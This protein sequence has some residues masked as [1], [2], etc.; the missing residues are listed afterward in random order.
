M[1]ETFEMKG[2]RE[3]V[4]DDLE[5]LAPLYLSFHEDDSRSE[6]E[7]REAYAFNVPKMFLEPLP[8]TKSSPSLVYEENGHVEGMIGVAARPFLFGDRRVWGAV[9]TLLIVSAEASRSLAGVRLVQ[10]ALAGPQDF[11]FVDQSNSAGRQTLRA[12]GAE[13]IAPYSLRWAK[14]L[15]P[16]AVK[17][18]RIAERRL[19]AR[20]RARSARVTEAVLDTE[21]QLPSSIK[22]RIVTEL[23]DRPKGAHVTELTRDDVVQFGPGLL[24]RFELRPDVGDADFVRSQWDLLELGRSPQRTAKAAVRSDRG[25]LLGWYIVHVPSNGEAEVVQFVAR[26]ESRSRVL[27]FLLRDAMERGALVVRGDA[28]PDLLFDL[29]DLGCTFRIHLSA[30][31]AHSGTDDGLVEAFRRSAAFVSGMEGETLINPADTWAGGR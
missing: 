29:S 23:P 6:R 2:I 24:S 3:L 18:T 15:R 26:P 5:A 16:G 28:V 8:G 20:L 13:T 25:K 10:S 1:N 7:L 11:T 17:A 4:E 19:P 12:A 31:S 30:F 14:T 27:T 22:R 9:T 21:H